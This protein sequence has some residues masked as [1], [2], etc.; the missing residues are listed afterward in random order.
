MEMN[1]TEKHSIV[2][3]PS[4]EPDS[5][6]PVYVKELKNYGL[7][8]IVIVDDG[9]GE[10]YRPVFQELEDEGCTVLWHWVNL[11]KGSAL[12]TGFKY[13][14][15]NLLDFSC[16]VTADA[17]G[18][19]APPD[20]YSLTKESVQHPNGLILGERDF[21]KSGIPA[22]SLFGNRITSAI[23]AMMYGKYLPDTQTGLRAF[24]P[25]LMDQMIEIKGSRFEYEIQVLI[26]CIR[27][28]V[29]ILSTSIQTIYENE[30]K[31]THFKAVKDSLRIMGAI[32]SDFIKFFSSSILC[33]A[34]DISIA[35]MLLDFLR[36]Y[37]QGADFLRIIYA[38]ITA[39]CVSIAANY[40]LNKNFVFKDKNKQ[41]G[42]RAFFRYL[43]LCALIMLLSAVSVYILH[44]TLLLN[45]KTAK[46]ICDICL[47]V[48]SYQIQ[49][50]WVFR[51]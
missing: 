36:P 8:H 47:F 11:G 48:L 35:W 49:Q 3:I 40:L 1:E 46:V 23:F 37:L 32:M 33:S 30:N 15:E 16:I 2:L 34:I 20:V 42:A 38:T 17:D 27:F 5:A 24:G 41:A 29:P 26:T 6:L 28:N 4:F 7:T 10:E 31:G 22:K 13:I 21:K 39:R 50:R 12:K 43:A 51:E 14:K 44:T 18:Q 9:S 25:Q 19:H 45:E